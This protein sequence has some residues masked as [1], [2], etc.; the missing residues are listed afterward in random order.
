LATELAI[1]GWQRARFRGG[2]E[3]LVSF[4]LP[5]HITGL[6]V[7]MLLHTNECF[8]VVALIGALPTT[9]AMLALV[10]FGVDSRRRSW[11]EIAAAMAL[12]GR[13]AGLDSGDRSPP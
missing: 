1:T 5:A 7:G 12:A 6:A 3:R 4:L 2:P 11:E 9:A 8:T 10:W 13:R